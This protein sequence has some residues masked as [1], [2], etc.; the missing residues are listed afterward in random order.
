MADYVQSSEFK[1][2]RHSAAKNVKYFPCCIEPFPDL[3]FVLEF[4]RSSGGHMVVVA[5]L[6]SQLML[7]IFW[8]PP[9]SPC[10]FG[11]CAFCLFMWPQNTMSRKLAKPVPMILYTCTA[12]SGIDLTVTNVL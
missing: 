10:R 2:T 3:T 7:V 9:H 5:V 11:L 8:M 4:K 6:T 12:I 1:V